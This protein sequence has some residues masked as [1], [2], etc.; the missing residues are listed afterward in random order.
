MIG[1]KSPSGAMCIAVESGPENGQ[2]TYSYIKIWD[3]FAEHMIDVTHDGKHGTSQKVYVFGSLKDMSEDDY[4][5]IFLIPLTYNS[6]KATPM[7][8]RERLMRE[9]LC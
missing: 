5:D 3:M 9:S 4:S 2:P 8:K 1:I 6:I 7:F